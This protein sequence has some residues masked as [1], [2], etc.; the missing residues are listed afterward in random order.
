MFGGCLALCDLIECVHATASASTAAAE[1]R[2][3]LNINFV[4]NEDTKR[5]SKCAR[6]SCGVLI[7]LSLDRTKY[8]MTAENV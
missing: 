1:I 4:N 5:L 3:F 2:L 6:L 7:I 8:R